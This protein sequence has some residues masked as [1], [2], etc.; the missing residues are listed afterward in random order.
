MLVS[1]LNNGIF[2]SCTYPKGIFPWTQGPRTI[3]EQT[4]NS[5][6]H[7]SGHLNPAATPSAI[8][9]IIGTVQ[10]LKRNHNSSSVN[11]LKKMKITEEKQ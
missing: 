8:N 9:V 7:V 1:H 6:P 11:K 5:F 2:V 3:K 10:K 4:S